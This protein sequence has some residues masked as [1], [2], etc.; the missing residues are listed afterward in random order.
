[1]LAGTCPPVCSPASDTSSRTSRPDGRGSTPS[2]PTTGTGTRLLK[3]KS[4]LIYS[5][6]QFTPKFSFTWQDTGPGLFHRLRRAMASGQIRTRARGTI[7]IKLHHAVESGWNTDFY[8]L[9]G[10]VERFRWSCSKNGKHKLICTFLEDFEIFFSRAFYSHCIG[11][12]CS[13]MRGTSIC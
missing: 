6:W 9:L 8:I 12:T 11:E 4:I 7:A 10:T 2:D 3:L 5:M 13:K 1:M